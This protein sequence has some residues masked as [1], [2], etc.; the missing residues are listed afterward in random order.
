[1]IAW[2]EPAVNLVCWKGNDYNFIRSCIQ[3]YALTEGGVNH[4]KKI[5]LQGCRYR[6]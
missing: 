4:G 6:L 1:M 3:R 5:K 2:A